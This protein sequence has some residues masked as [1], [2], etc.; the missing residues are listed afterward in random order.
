MD[1]R[2]FGYYIINVSFLISRPFPLID[3]K[4]RAFGLREYST[5]SHPRFLGILVSLVNRNFAGYRVKQLR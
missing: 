1:K 2:T 5:L 4:F 3:I